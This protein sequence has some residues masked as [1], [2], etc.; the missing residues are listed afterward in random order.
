MIRFLA[1]AKDVLLDSFQ[2]ESGTLP[3]SYPLSTRVTDLGVQRPDREAG[4]SPSSSAGI[5]NYGVI[6]SLPYTS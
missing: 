1:L 6:R 2:T 4:Q 3:A 5:K